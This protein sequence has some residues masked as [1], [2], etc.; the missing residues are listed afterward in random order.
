MTTA[1]AIVEREPLTL[2]DGRQLAV[3][4]AGDPDG[5]V[6]LYLHGTGSSRLEVALY[7]EAAARHG[8]RLVAWDRPGA[9]RSSFQPGRRLRDVLDDARAVAASVGA[10]RPVAFGHSGGG[11][12]VVALASAAPHVIRA[13]V[14]INPGGPSDDDTL[15]RLPRQFQWTIRAARDRPWVFDLLGRMME[16]RGNRVIDAV[17]NRAVD[18]AD[19]ALINDPRIRPL[20]EAAAVEGGLQPRAYTKE[21]VMF[22]T[23]PWDISLTTFAVPLHV[24]AGR[25]DPFRSFAESLGRAGAQL[26]WFDGGHVFC[27]ADPVMEDL[28]SQIA[29]L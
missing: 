25:D 2:T 1:D 13:G 28:L 21:A 3:C 20:F 9:G 17:K 8:I 5:P 10:D 23:Q 12:H 16:H 18:P 11:T 7:G 19:R 24:Y 27:F 14:A 29:A 4:E 26:H 22:W 15:S 6:A